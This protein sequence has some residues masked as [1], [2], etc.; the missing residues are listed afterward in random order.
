MVIIITIVKYYIL[1]QLIKKN[2]HLVLK[3]NFY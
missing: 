1:K 3:N 2:F